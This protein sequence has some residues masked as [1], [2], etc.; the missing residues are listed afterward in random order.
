MLL[1]IT[2][3]LWISD[4]HYLQ[5][6]RHSSMW[7]ATSGKTQSEYPIRAKSIKWVELKKE[8]NLSC[9][10]FNPQLV[11]FNFMCEFWKKITCC[12]K[13]TSFFWYGTPGQGLSNTK[14]I[15]MLFTIVF[16]L[17]KAIK[18][19]REHSKWHRTG[20][21]SIKY[22]KLKNLFPVGF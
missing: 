19:Y 16:L 9:T 5:L 17:C 18:D 22:I 2:I 13:V 11:L 20:V 15:R 10:G 1:I 12:S 8:L 6:H 21:K 7:F 4:T 3:Q 14:H